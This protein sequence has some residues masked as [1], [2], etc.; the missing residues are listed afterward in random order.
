MKNQINSLTPRGRKTMLSLCVSLFLFHTS[1]YSQIG[2]PTVVFP[3]GGQTLTIGSTVTIQ[4]T[5]TALNT[6][7]GIDYTID[8]WVTTT[9]LNTNYSNPTANTYTWVVPNTP[10][11]LCKIGIFNT[12]FQGDISDNFFTIAAPSGSAP[13]ANFNFS[14]SLCTG[15][16][17]SFADQ[18]TDLPNAWSWAVVPSASITTP[19]AQNTVIKFPNPG[20][21]TVSLIP[22]NLNGA[23]TPASKTIAINASPSVSVVSSAP[24]ICK[25]TTATLT[26]SG[27]NSYSWSTA[28]SSASIVITPPQTTGYTLTGTAVNGCKSTSAFT[29]SVSVCTAI[30]HITEQAQDPVKIYPNPTKNFFCI[31]LIPPVETDAYAFELY[32]SVGKIVEQK[33]LPAGNHCIQTSTLTA[34]IYYLKIHDGKKLLK[35]EKII[36]Q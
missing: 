32:N 5:G 20:I 4:W 11:T 15:A 12:N 19:A 21:Y 23:G 3:N 34:G 27:A 30:N 16:P 22:S 31:E 24:V 8:N 10:G 14:G 1:A 25:G 28:A 33:K 7:V 6:V 29:Q 26:A 36:I 35:T 17:V 18:S 2:T 9:W 13:T